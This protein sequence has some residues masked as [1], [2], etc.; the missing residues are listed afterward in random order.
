M[1]AGLLG[2]HHIQILLR[3]E[4]HNDAKQPE[5]IWKPH[6]SCAATPILLEKQGDIC[7]TV[8]SGS[9]SVII[10]YK[11]DKENTS[12]QWEEWAGTLPACWRWPKLTQGSSKPQE[13]RQNQL[14]RSVWEERDSGWYKILF[15]LIA[16]SCSEADCIP[17]LVMTPEWVPY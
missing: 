17:V 7:R 10:P 14:W 11:D 6:G 3:D 8:T 2:H 13:V 1:K 4:E 12:L 9:V 16:F 15:L 5:Q